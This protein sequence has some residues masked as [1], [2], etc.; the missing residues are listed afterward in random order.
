MVLKL[1]PLPFDSRFRAEFN[2]SG[3][4]VLIATTGPAVWVWDATSGK[5]IGL[6]GH[7]PPSASDHAVMQAMLNGITMGV[8][9]APEGTHVLTVGY[10]TAPRLWDTDTGMHVA[11][12]AGHTGIVWQAAF[13]HAGRYV[14]TAS[15]DG[16]AH[17]WRVLPTTKALVDFAKHAVPR[18][19]ALG[20]YD[21]FYT[22]SWTASLVH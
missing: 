13:H 21:G 22:Q 14:V 4:R 9:F 1:R 18:C 17:I 8:R 12:L 11:I 10:D 20:Q 5:E 3:N 15:N 16:T 6:L 7:A 2:P 19:L